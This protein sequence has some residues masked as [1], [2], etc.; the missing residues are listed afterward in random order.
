M[1]EQTA[2]ARTTNLA[3]TR[4]LTTAALIAALIG[5]SAFIAIPL[6]GGVPLTLQVFFVV[7]GALLLV[8]EW[9]FAAMATYV[10]LGAVGLPVFSGG[11][12]GL[13]VLA[14]P[15]GGFLFGFAV[16][17]LVGA[18]VRASLVNRRVVPVIAD[19]VAAA[20]VIVV[21]YLVGTVQLGIVLDLP[22]GGAFAAGA[23]PFI[24]G[25]AA[26]A[27]AAVGVASA[28]RRARGY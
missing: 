8:P 27:V 13:G 3:R 25:D 4:E 19:A 21:V 17:A 15:T 16:A 26:K 11:R 10:A 28:V 14:G 24:A 6:P 18:I 5:A 9:A 20:A 12:G 7:L 23:L 2:A 1:V 22:A